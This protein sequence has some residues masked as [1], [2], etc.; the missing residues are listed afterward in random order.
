MG[1]EWAQQ[2]DA[3]SNS[4]GWWSDSQQ[5]WWVKLIEIAT[6]PMHGAPASR[7]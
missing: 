2:C 7:C 5:S 4:P 1:I 3:V 6:L